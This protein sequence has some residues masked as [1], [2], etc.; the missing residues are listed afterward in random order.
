MLQV[1][2]KLHFMAEASQMDN[3]VESFPGNWIIVLLDLMKNETTKL[4]SIIVMV[5]F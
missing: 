2:E 3:T 4:V 1:T 5:V